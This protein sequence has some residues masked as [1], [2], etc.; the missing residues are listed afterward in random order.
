MG[1]VLAWIRGVAAAVVLLTAGVFSPRLRG[2]LRQFAREVGVAK[3]HVGPFPAKRPDFVGDPTLPLALPGLDAQ[4]GNVSA[5]ELA[6]LARL[7]KSRA[8]ML[9]WEIGTFDGRTTRVLAANAPA[10]A[11]VHT[12]DLP[13]DG[14]GRTAHA[15]SPSERDLV[16]KPSSGARFA[17][18]PEQAKIT[19]HLG[20]SATFDFTPWRRQADFVFVDGSHAAA[21]VVS[22]TN[23]AGLLT[24]DRKAVVV[25]HDYGEWP[26]VTETLD[27]LAPTLKG[28]YRVAGTTLVVW[29]RNV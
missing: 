6:V 11:Q 12:L 2:Y 14:L 27:T 5:L 13:A 10:G 1:F 15:L 19:Q 18:T 9:L 4:D 8:P 3:P 16:K 21:Y 22:D 23:R 24:D 17:G 25:W 26:G 28:A 29:E 7:V 20:D